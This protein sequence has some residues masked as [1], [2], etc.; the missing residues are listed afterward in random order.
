[1]RIL[2]VGLILVVEACAP[3]IAHRPD[4]R[5]GITGGVTAALGN[6]P[7]YEN[8]DDPGPF[9]SGALMANVGYGFRPTTESRPAVSIGLQGPTVENVAL[10]FY[11]QAPRRWF[12][13]VAGGVGVLAEFSGGRQMPYLQAGTKNGSGVSV[14]VA[15]GRY[16]R[17]Y[18]SKFGYSR[19]ERAQVGW[20]SLEVPLE[21]HMSVYLRGGYASGHVT[22]WIGPGS[23]PYI[24]EDRHVGLGGVSIELHR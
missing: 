8:G 10:D 22:K 14:D 15:V 17:S 16:T 1:M 11:L 23:I 20:L 4:V 12:G 21:K 9:Y 6:G 7:T 19:Q 2:I 3:V 24:D 5:Q 18:K 13:P